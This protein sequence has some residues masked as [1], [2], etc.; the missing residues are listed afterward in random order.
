MDLQEMETGRL[1]FVPDDDYGRAALA[2]WTAGSPKK[3]GQG[4]PKG[5]RPCF[6]HTLGRCA[7][8]TQPLRRR[9]LH[10]ARGRRRLR[11]QPQLHSVLLHR[12][13]RRGRGG[14]KIF[15]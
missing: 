9:L 3:L 4:S 12:G 2:A 7:A 15:D 1:R 5:A 14:G 6:P 10:R 13:Q 8:V 11:A